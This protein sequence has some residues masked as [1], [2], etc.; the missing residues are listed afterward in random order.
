MTKC[1]DEKL[2]FDF[3]NLMA[4]CTDGAS[5]TCGKKNVGAVALLE[6]LIGRHII[7]HHCIMRGGFRK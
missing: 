7:K 4:I 3:T 2:G 1:V 5:A 6:E